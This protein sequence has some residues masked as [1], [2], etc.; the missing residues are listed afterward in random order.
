MFHR[1]K[2]KQT[3]D[4]GPLI[5]SLDEAAEYSVKDPMNGFYR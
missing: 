5:L 4:F 1:E 3:G 2:W